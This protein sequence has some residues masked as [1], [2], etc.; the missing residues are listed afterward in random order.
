MIQIQSTILAE[1]KIIT[2][3]VHG[4]ARGYFLESYHKSDLDAALGA[5]LNFV[6]DNQSGSQRGVLRGLHYQLKQAQGKLVRVVSGEIFDV[7]VDIRRSSRQFMHWFGLRLSADSQQQLWL[8]AGYA[9]GFLVLSSWAE[10]AYKATDYY[11]PE[12]ERCIR[13]DDP[14][15]GIQWPGTMVPE[16]SPRDDRAPT[17]AEAE[18]PER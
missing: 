6:Q 16:L 4:D 5:E 2:P 3:T 17:C 15:I 12:H 1:V 9:H 13:Y 11:A 10:V 14:D 18:L 8:P 7:A